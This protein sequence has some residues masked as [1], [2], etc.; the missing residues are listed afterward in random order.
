MK[1]L[2]TW[3]LD[4]TNRPNKITHATTMN[5]HIKK[6]ETKGEAWI[7]CTFE[8]ISYGIDI[9]PSLVKRTR[10]QKIEDLPTNTPFTYHPNKEE[11]KLE[12]DEKLEI[13]EEM[14]SCSHCKQ[15]III[16]KVTATKYRSCPLVEIQLSKPTTEDIVVPVT[17]GFS[18]L[19]VYA[20]L[21]L[22]GLLSILTAFIF[23]IGV[24]SNSL[25]L[26]GASLIVCMLSFSKLWRLTNWTRNTKKIGWTKYKDG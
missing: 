24:E 12:R 18:Y 10:K 11:V 14:E 3:F 4:K 5:V 6:G 20:F 7:P 2:I 17:Y 8:T 9:N 15:P 26:A 25:F 1:K 21:G 19:Q 23:F 16:A 22:Y 13:L